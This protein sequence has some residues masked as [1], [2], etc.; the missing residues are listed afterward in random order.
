[1]RCPVGDGSVDQIENFDPE[2]S[3]ILLIG[4]K[5]AAFILPARLGVRA[6]S[7]SRGQTHQPDR[8]EP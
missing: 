6:W 1:V 3:G 7:T 4:R 8:K 2:R 5:V